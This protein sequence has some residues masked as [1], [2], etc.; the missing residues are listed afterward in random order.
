MSFKELNAQIVFFKKQEV[1][2]TDED[3]RVILKD[4]IKNI[5]AK[6]KDIVNKQDSEPI[7]KT[8]ANH[9]SQNAKLIERT[10]AAQ[11]T[12][13]GTDTVEAEEFLNKIDQLYMLLV[14]EVDPSLESD[15]VMHAKLKFGSNV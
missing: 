9:Q 15:F 10:L 13:Y 8:E 5:Y 7:L 1:E 2:C 12:F 11:P 3:E 6:I 14:K 4:N